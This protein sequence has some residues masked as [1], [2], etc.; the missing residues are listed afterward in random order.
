M[1]IHLQRGDETHLAQ[2]ETLVAA[3]HEFEH[4]PSLPQQRARA[5][6]QLIANPSLGA[7]WLIEV[8]GVVAGY[9]ALC[10]GFSIEFAGFD[11]FIDEFY[12]LPEFRGRGVGKQVLTEIAEQARRLDINAL[13]LEVARDNQAARKLYASAG[14]AARD[15]YL[16]MSRIISDAK[17]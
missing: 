11:A 3:Y 13:H 4:I 8:E 10:R 6:R 17:D 5:I 9:I 12:L 2:L 7:I 1:T 16:L 15:K 14:F